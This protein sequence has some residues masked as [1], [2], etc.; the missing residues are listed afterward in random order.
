MPASWWEEIE[1]FPADGQ[2]CMSDYV[3]GYVWEV[4]LLMIG[5]VLVVLRHPA[6][7]DASRWGGAK[8]QIQVEVFVGIPTD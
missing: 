8:S 3:L 1:F 5:F 7:G 4:C 6:L 2:D